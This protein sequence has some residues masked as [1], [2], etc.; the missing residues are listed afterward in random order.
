MHAHCVSDSAKL[1]VGHSLH[2]LDP[3]L[4]ID[5]SEHGVHTSEPVADGPR[6]ESQWEEDAIRGCRSGGVVWL[7]WVYAPGTLDDVPGGHGA[8]AAMLLLR[9]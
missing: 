4:E 9:K 2:L 5:E 1:C 8:H 6:E 7:L 3:S